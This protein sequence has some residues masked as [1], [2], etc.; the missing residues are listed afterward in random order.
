MRLFIRSLFGRFGVEAA[1][2]HDV[3]ESLIVEKGR[4]VF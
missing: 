2:A 1:T 4:I 3:E